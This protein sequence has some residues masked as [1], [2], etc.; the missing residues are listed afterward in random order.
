MTRY[1]RFNTARLAG[2]VCW[3]VFVVATLIAGGVKW[4]P[5]GII[6]GTTGTSCAPPVTGRIAYQPFTSDMPRAYADYLPSDGWEHAWV[7]PPMY[8]LVAFLA[9]MICAVIQAAAMPRVSAAAVTVLVPILS[10]AIIAFAL[11]DGVWWGFCPSPVNA[12]ILTLVGVAIREV[13]ARG[14]APVL[15]PTG[16]LS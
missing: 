9:V 12:L 2:H 3:W 7:S 4:L 10:A 5:V 13:W 6:L 16:D 11:S 1:K 14:V 8:S 15:A